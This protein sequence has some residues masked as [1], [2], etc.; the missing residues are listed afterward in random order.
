MSQNVASPEVH[1]HRWERWTDC[2]GQSGRRAVTVD[3][4]SALM[5]ALLGYDVP[6]GDV[7]REFERLIADPDYEE[8]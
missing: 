4:R 1:L 3:H 7:L 6:A 5:D 2:K 8:N